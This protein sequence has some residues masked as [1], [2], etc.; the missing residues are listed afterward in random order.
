M[1]EIYHARIPNIYYICKIHQ[2]NT[3]INKYLGTLIEDEGDWNNHVAKWSFQHIYLNMFSF[4]SW[5]D[6][7]ILKF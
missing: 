4:Q 1:N 7:F 2:T 3:H 6:K 5:L